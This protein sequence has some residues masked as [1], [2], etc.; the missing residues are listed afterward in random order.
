MPSPIS[1][2]RAATVV[3][4]AREGRDDDFGSGTHETGAPPEVRALSGPCAYTPDPGSRDIALG[5]G[6]VSHK[7]V[8]RRRVEITDDRNRCP[9]PGRSPQG[10]G[11]ASDND[12]RPQRNNFLR[13]RQQ[14]S[15]RLHESVGGP[16]GRAQSAGAARKLL[17]IPAACSIKGNIARDGERIY[18]VPSGQFYGVTVI[19]TGQGERWFVMRLA[20]TPLVIAITRDRSL[21][22]SQ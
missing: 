14:S 4:G 6:K 8:D 12:V 19:N 3:P 10:D 15:Q 5:T 18:H 21:R 7:L 11:Q 17:H 2:P 9:G 16:S 22:S 13:H 1:D 20:P